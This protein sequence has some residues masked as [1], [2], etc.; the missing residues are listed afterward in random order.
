MAFRKKR[1]RD[2]TWDEA[3]PWA[4]DLKKTLGH[5]QQN[6]EKMMRTLDETLAL[7]TE[8]TDRLDSVSELVKGLRTQV[9]DAL[10]GLALPPQVQAKVDAIF[11]KAEAQ[12]AEI[13]EALNTNVEPPVTPPVD[14]VDPIDP[15][16]GTGS[17]P[18]GQPSDP[19]NPGTPTQ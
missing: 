16:A 10:S 7:V 3:P 13:D 9:A 11:A 18:T 2:R 5:I 14:P 1:D 12:R 17:G 8:N 19:A 6:Q 4:V 15:N